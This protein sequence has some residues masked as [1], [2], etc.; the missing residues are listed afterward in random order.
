M[1]CI[2]QLIFP[3]YYELLYFQKFSENSNLSCL[4]KYLIMND[5]G[6]SVT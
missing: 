6:T 2:S 5:I 3:E 1:S 4:K